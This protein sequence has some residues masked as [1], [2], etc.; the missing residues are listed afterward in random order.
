MPKRQR[1]SRAQTRRWSR[2][3]RRRKSNAWKNGSK[4][5]FSCLKIYCAPEKKTVS[6]ISPKCPQVNLT[7]SKSSLAHFASRIFVKNFDVTNFRLPP[8]Y[9]SSLFCHRG[10]EKLSF[11]RSISLW[12]LKRFKAFCATFPFGVD[13]KRFVLLK[14][15]NFCTQNWHLSSKAFEE[16]SHIILMAWEF[17][18]LKDFQ[19][20]NLA[21]PACPKML[22]FCEKVPQN[23]L[24]P[25]LITPSLLFSI[26]PF[27]CSTLCFKDEKY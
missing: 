13:L 9:L 7:F 10:Q 6:E 8:N 18:K 25:L 12:S 15:L 20:I 4:R 21:Y 24:T 3:C 26:Y 23:P 5:G 27:K 22:H 19:N 16:V 11:V 17:G 2:M 1:H 14:V